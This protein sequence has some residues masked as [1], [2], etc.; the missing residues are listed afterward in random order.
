MTV[1]TNEEWW[2]SSRSVYYNHVTCMVD[3][4]CPRAGYRH[5]SFHSRNCVETQRSE[6]EERAVCMIDSM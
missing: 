3:T 1:G 6:G 4:W 5:I 2:Y